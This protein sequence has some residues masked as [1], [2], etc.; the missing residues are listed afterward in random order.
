[1]KRPS[2]RDELAAHAFSLTDE[3][4]E[5]RNKWRGMIGMAIWLLLSGFSMIVMLLGSGAKGQTNIAIVIGMSFIKYAPLL[6][7]VY[8]LARI[9][10]ARYLDDVYELND[11]DIASDFLEEVAFGYGRHRITINEGKISEADERSPLILIGGPG[12]IQVNLDSVALLE[13]VNGEPKVIYPRSDPWK[14]GRFERIREI[15]KFDEVGKREYAIIN[16]R[17]QFVSGLTVKSRTKDGIPLEAHDIKVIFSILR[18][19]KDKAQDDAYLFDDQAVQSLVYNQTII[20]P[21]PSTPSGI[22]FPWDTTVIPLIV[23]ELEDLIKSHNL[24]EILANIS[25]KEMETATTNDQAIEQMRLDMTRQQAAVEIK[26]NAPTPK[27]EA[28]SKIT[29]QFFE[30]SFTKKAAAIGVAIDWIDIGTWQLPSA[31]ILDKHKEAWKLS[32]E[33]ANKRGAMERFRKKQETDEIIKLINSVVIK[34]FE[35]TTVNRISDKDFKAWVK[36]N[37]D[38]LDSNVFSR[39]TMQQDVQKKDARS[40]AL[41]MLGAFRRELR[42]GKVIIE[43]ENKLQEEKIAETASIEKALHNIA[44]ITTHWIKR[45]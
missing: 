20:T 35:K 44:H 41:E 18:R 13:T 24:G 4:V 26:Q 14:L 19:E 28:R 16:L 36:D 39:Q 43:S 27:F 2:W 5:F 12:S 7:V 40:I 34:S 22:N 30:E 45:S 3:G 37:A 21:E 6:M 25:Q 8:N 31:L 17:D 32:R 10:A 11:E 23:S 1:M 9:M 15:G 42:A 33:N 29:S 38:L